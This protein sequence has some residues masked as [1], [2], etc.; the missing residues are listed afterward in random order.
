[1]LRASLTLPAREELLRLIQIRLDAPKVDGPQRAYWLAAGLLV[2]PDRCLPLA[3]CYLRRRPPAAQHLADF[4]RGI[5]DD[6]ALPSNVLGVLIEHLAVGCSPGHFA[7]WVSPAMNRADLVKRFLNDLSGRPDAASAEQLD[8][9][10]SLPELA[11][12]ASKLR[13]AQFAQRVVRRD[14]TYERPKWQQVC[15]ALHQGAPANPAEIAAV[16]NDTIEDLK[17]QVHRSDLDLNH[18]Y[19]NVD[20]HGSAKN[21]RHEERCRD[22]FADQLRVRLE[23]FEIGCMPEAHHAEGKRSDVWCTTG[24]RGVPIEVKRDQHRELWTA[25]RGQLIARYASDPRA[26]GRGIYAV[27][28]F[29]DLKKVPL[30]PSGARPQTPEEL[31][32]MLE[33]SLS[34]EEK[35]LVTIHVLDCS[36]RS[37]K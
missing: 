19:W 21:P 17:E 29:G 7:D 22:T 4:L 27:L 10:Q 14:A 35:R 13:E 37:G 26:G 23:R 33:A 11:G 6:I 30:P 36:V 28:W 34:E 32:A 18:Q 9:L 20:E 5:G 15:E 12:W 8:R 3:S 2:D 24:T 16:V 31:E 1:M 25:T